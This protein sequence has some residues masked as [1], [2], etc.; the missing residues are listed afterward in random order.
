MYGQQAC[1]VADSGQPDP[2]TATLSQ[3]KGGLHSKQQPNTIPIPMSARGVKQIIDLDRGLHLKA[4]SYQ[5]Q[6]LRKI[7]SCLTLRIAV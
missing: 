5:F 6:S 3:D 1:L 2:R 7:V 4:T